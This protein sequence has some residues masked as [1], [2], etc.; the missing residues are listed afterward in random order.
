MSNQKPKQLYQLNF[1]IQFMF[2]NGTESRITRS[3]GQ[4]HK[5]KHNSETV[6]QTT[7]WA[8]AKSSLSNPL[9]N[10]DSHNNDGANAKQVANE[11]VYYS[12]YK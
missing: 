8:L 1:F 10:D 3:Q 4:N 7:T 9:G 6:T 2:I 11:N 5:Y 12:Y